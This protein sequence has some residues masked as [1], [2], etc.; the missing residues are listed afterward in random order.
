MILGETDKYFPDQ[1]A[2]IGILISSFFNSRVGRFSC[3]IAVEGKEIPLASYEKA[4]EMKAA[5]AFLVYQLL[6]INNLLSI[7]TYSVRGLFTRTIS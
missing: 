7:L 6:Y 1:L 3:Y 4:I 2:F 5:L